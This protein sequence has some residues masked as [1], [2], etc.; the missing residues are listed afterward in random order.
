MPPLTGIGRYT[1]E[2]AKCLPAQDTVMSVRYFSRGQWMPSL[3]SHLQQTAT[4]RALRKRLVLNRYTRRLYSFFA[5]ALIQRQLAAC[6]DAIFHGTNFNV[7][8]FPG[9]TVATFHDLS[10]YRY[11]EF[12]PAARVEFMRREIPKT[13]QRADFLIAVSEFTRR[14]VIDYFNWPADKIRSIPLGVAPHYHPRDIL[15]TQPVLSGMGLR[16][17]RY[18]LCVAT[19]EPRKNLERTLTAYEL[20]PQNVRQRYPLVLVGASGWEN[21]NLLARITKGQ[22]EG[23]ILYLGF[24]PESDLPVVVAGAHLFI[25]PSLYEGFGLPVVEAMASGVPVLTS[26]RASLPEISQGAAML[27][28]PEDI[29]GMTH[30]IQQCLEDTAWR[31]DAS[32]LGLKVAAQYDW[33]LT[34]MR[35]A[36]VYQKLAGL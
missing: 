18:A 36:D 15:E 24:V 27:V 8:S 13:L 30:A 4:K 21:S 31:K 25:F 34:A 16:H 32:Q 7:P 23:W 20:L 28:E 22:R 33:S 10:V 12:H 26:N 9:R 29:D 17:G 6:A 5:P 14:E 3:E 35:T 19:I 1:W 11:P 2:L